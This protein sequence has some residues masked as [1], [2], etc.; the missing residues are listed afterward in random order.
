VFWHTSGAYAK[1]NAEL[2][3]VPMAYLLRTM[4]GALDI[5]AELLIL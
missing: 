1:T 3:S 4:C 5:I 2:C